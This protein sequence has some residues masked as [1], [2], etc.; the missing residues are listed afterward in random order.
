MRTILKPSLLATLGVFATASMAHHGSN[1][2]FDTT[3]EIQVSGVVTDIKLVNPHSYVYFDVTNEDG[4]VDPWRCELRGGSLLKRTGWSSEMFATGTELTIDGAPARREEFGCMVQTITFADGRIVGRND[5]LNADEE[6]AAAA[7]VVTKLADGTPNFNGNWAAAQESPGGPGGPGAMG[8][9]G[10]GAMGADGGMGPGGMGGGGPQYTL[11][12]AGEA[13]SA[14]FESADN[15]RYHCKATNIFHDWW[16]D[17][18]V[19]M[20]EQTNDKIVMTYGF[21]DIV[22]TIHLDMDSHPADIVPSIAG[23]SIGSWDGDT[24]VVDTVG[25]SEG[26]LDG[27]GGVKHS[28][29]LHTVER[30]S[31]S[32]DGE[33]LTI[34]YTGED[35]LYLVGSFTGTRDVLRTNDAFQPYECDDLT[36]EIV[37]G[38]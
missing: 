7:P 37:P 13:A 21:M 28:S 1:G 31:L 33:T 5:V 34:D 38:F 12:D 23:H 6:N 29:A 2:Q 35:P 10:M 9:G 11:T 30:M 20:I 15:P 24:L 17:Q 25:F 4:S 22:R 27:R 18:N 32:E 16:F 3:K 14:G 26:Y 19:N 36:E 8:A